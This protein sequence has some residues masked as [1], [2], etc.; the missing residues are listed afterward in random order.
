MIAEVSA[1]IGALNA[2]NGAINTIR[3]TKG[4]VQSL[5]KVADYL[6]IPVMCYGIRTDFQGK[7]FEGRQV[8]LALADNLNELKEG[9][10]VV[11]ILADS[12]RN[13]LDKFVY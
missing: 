5:S 2:V 9:D 12:G 4:N 11:A 10:Y 7:L 1:V 3:E 6:A 8:L 13:Y